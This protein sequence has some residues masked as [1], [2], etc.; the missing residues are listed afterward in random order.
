MLSMTAVSISMYCSFGSADLPPSSP[1]PASCCYS[2]VHFNCSW[3]LSA[4]RRSISNF[5]SW[6]QGLCTVSELRVSR[7]CRKS[8]SS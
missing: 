8:D 1:L 3:A 7:S 2:D 4:I 5:I 6:S